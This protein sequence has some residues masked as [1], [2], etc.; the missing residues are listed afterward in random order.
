MDP[1]TQ[2]V[3][4]FVDTIRDY[5]DNSQARSRRCSDSE[6]GDSPMPFTHLSSEQ[7]QADTSSCFTCLAIIELPW[8]DSGLR[9]HGYSA[10]NEPREQKFGLSTYSCAF[11]RSRD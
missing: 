6:D 2:P 7:P 8:A 10:K 3:G 11:I 5:H 4:E 1:E 9:D